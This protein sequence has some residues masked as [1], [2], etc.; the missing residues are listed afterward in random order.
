MEGQLVTQ[1]FVE[2]SLKSLAVALQEDEHLLVVLS[3]KVPLGQELTHLLETDS[4]KVFCNTGHWAT[5]KLEKSSAKKLVW[6]DEGSTHKLL[7][8]LAYRN[9]GH[10]N[11]HL[12]LTGFP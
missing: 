12:L 1:R 3:A 6:H 8:L 7:I 10:F 11:T 2:G 5:Q 4:P 9:S